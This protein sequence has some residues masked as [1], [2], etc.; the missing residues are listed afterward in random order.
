MAVT[1]G[2][3]T[4]LAVGPTTATL[5]SAVATAGVGPYEYQWYRSQTSG[6]SPGGGSIIAD[7]EALVLNDSGLI[8]GTIYY[9]KVVATDTGDSNATSTSAQLVVTTA[10][11]SLSQN[12]FGMTEYL[13]AI[14]MRFPYNTVSVQIDQ[15]QS[16]PLYAGSPVKM[17]DSAGGVPKVV[18]CTADTDEVLGFINYNIKNQQFLAGEGAEISMSGN[19]MYLYSS[20]AIARGVEVVSTNSVTRGSV[21]GVTGASAKRIVGWAYDKATA[22][23]QLIRVFLKTPS[24]SVDS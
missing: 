2:A 14:D 20:G 13:G 8:P 12:Q 24:F 9:Y 18:G 6:F 22:P 1:A 3:L 4:Q 21:L 10:A 5:Q 11:P 19:V 17:V 15:S 7:A 16:T 23:G